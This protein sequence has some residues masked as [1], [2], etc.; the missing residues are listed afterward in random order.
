MPLKCEHCEKPAVWRVTPRGLRKQSV[1][2]CTFHV[3]SV[4]TK[5][6]G[7]VVEGLG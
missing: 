7:G 3:A 5:K 1:F 2:T 6:K 4:L